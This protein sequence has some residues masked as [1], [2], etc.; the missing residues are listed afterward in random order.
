MRSARPI[1]LA[2]VAFALSAVVVPP[3]SAA[4]PVEDAPRHCTYI[5]D[6]GKVACFNTLAKAQAFNAKG[7]Y[8]DL[9]RIWSHS[10]SGGD[11]LTYRGSV[12]CGWRY[13]EFSYIGDFW[14][15]KVSSAQGL[16]CPITLWEHSDFRGAHQTYHGYNAYVGDGMNDKA[17]SIS[18]DLH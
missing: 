5:V 10:N 13:P 15:D 18:F 16:A 17:S 4:E 9:G 7:E 6:T 14:N 1:A 11:S 3:A 8:R 2:A 12:G